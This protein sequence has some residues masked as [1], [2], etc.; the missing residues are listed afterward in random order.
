[1]S[2]LPQVFLGEEITLVTVE[3]LQKV[4]NHMNRCLNEL[5]KRIEAL[6]KNQPQAG[7]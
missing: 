5:V 7:E 6:E 3:Q 4:I 1:M 2:E